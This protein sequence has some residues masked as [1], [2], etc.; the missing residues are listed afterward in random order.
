MMRRKRLCR[1]AGSAASK[2]LSAPRIAMAIVFSLLFCNVPFVAQAQDIQQGE[3]A[4]ET[5]QQSP[6]PLT[7]LASGQNPATPQKTSKA[8]FSLGRFIIVSVGAFPFSYF[9]TN[10][11]FDSVKFVANG[12]D[13][14]YAP[15]PFNSQSSSSVTTSERFIR[16]GVSAG[17]CLI[18]GSLDIFLPRDW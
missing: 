4:V 6:I 12:F 16:L 8:S 5:T 18:V 17:L 2:A 10:F 15:W 1:K 9:Y 11:A 7:Y 3:P 13:T 14:T